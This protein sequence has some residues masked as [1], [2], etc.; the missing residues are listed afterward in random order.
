MVSC[1]TLAS[2]AI[3]AILIKVQGRDFDVGILFTSLTLIMI[4]IDPIFTL[5]QDVPNLSSALVCLTRV[6]LFLAS[7]K[8]SSKP[9]SYSNSSFG[10]T[11][12]SPPSSET[13]LKQLKPIATSGD[14]LSAADATFGWSEDKPILH[15][16]T[17]NI[18]WR[19]VNVVIGP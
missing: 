8:K 4:A 15:N 6:Q 2:F 14:V 17:L 3:Y 12:S 10:I 1:C 13:T 11:D 7:E 16:V 19:S 5:I 9:R 18:S